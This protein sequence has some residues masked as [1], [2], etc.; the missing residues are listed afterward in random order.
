M[1]EDQPILKGFTQSFSEPENDQEQ[2]NKRFYDNKD[3]LR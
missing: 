2:K 3:F 1:W